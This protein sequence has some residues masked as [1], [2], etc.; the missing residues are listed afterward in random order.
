MRKSFLAMC[1]ASLAGLWA[2]TAYSAQTNMQP[3]TQIWF[4]GS[5]DFAFFTGQGQWTAPG[6]SATYIQIHSSVPARDKILALAMMAHA[7]GKKVL[8]YGECS[9][10]AG[11]FDATY[12]VVSD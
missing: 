6:C 7:S 5:I 12:I 11:Y 9:A 4:N 8:F 1:L 2:S 3:I 10:S